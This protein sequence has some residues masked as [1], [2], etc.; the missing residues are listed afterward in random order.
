MPRWR[1]RSVR[2]R[3]AL[4]YSAAVGLVVLI[5]AAGVYTFVSRSLREELD[6]SLHDDFEI[7]EQSLET[8]RASDATAWSPEQGHHTDG[9]E[10]VRWSEVWGPVG[11]LRFRSPGLEERPAPPTAAAG[12]EYASVVGAAGMPLRTLS[13]AHSVGASEFVVR[14]TR[15]EEGVRHELN[16]LLMGLGLGLPIAVVLAGVGGYQ[17]ARRALRPVEHM[18]EQAQSITADHLRARLPVDNP[19]DELGRLATVFNEML[20]RIEEAF[21][22]LRRFTADASHELRTPLTAIRS[23]GEV[24]LR[25]RDGGAALVPLL[26]LA[27]EVTG[28]LSVLAEERAQTIDVE[29]EAS[30]EARA[31]PMLIREALINLVDNAIKYS[32]RGARV[33]VRV[34][35]DGREEA[36]LEVTDTGPGIDPEH[37]ARIFERFYRVDQ[38]RS[39]DQGG[40]GLG[41][42]I[43]RWAVAA[44][45][46]RIELESEVG[47]GSTFRIVLASALLSSQVTGTERALHDLGQHG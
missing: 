25:E 1:P 45:G 28:H 2:L 23:V 14:V 36:A 16:E 27:R 18:T 20:N 12:Y 10:P 42:A 40:S 22:R 5:Y 17:L 21:E 37:H 47:R 7:V 30:I 35:S 29:G 43:A 4:W 6:R 26:A 31:D 33:H 13:G 24:G 11:Q 8:A 38:G 41:L 19:D 44:N 32:P 39:R 15:S 3:L 46:G 9:S 34:F